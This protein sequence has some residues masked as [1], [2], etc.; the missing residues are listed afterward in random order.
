MWH[1]WDDEPSEQAHS[2]PHLHD[3]FFD[4]VLDDR[5]GKAVYM[6]YCTH[7]L[8]PG[9]CVRHS[10]RENSQ[11]IQPHH[12]FRKAHGSAGRQDDGMLRPDMLRRIGYPAF[13]VRRD[14]RI[15]G[16]HDQWIPSDCSGE[17]KDHRSQPLGKEKDRFPNDPDYSCNGIP[18]LRIRYDLGWIVHIHDRDHRLAN[19]NVDDFPERRLLVCPN[20]DSSLLGR[21][22]EEELGGHGRPVLIT[23]DFHSTLGFIPRCLA[24]STMVK[25]DLLFMLDSSLEMDVYALVTAP[26]NDELLCAHMVDSKHRILN[27]CAPFPKFTGTK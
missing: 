20:P 3:S 27:F 13:M 5:R 22:Y 11:K 4:F 23:G 7:H 24:I 15:Q 21:L 9:N 26:S 6:G 10:R 8:H 2:I 18:V 14:H 17:R 19:H 1:R 25:S 12:R 16:V